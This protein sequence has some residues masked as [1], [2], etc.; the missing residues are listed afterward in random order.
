MAYRGCY[1]GVEIKP[2][3]PL[4]RL[5]LMVQDRLEAARIQEVM[6]GALAATG[7]QGLNDAY[8][9][10][11]QLSIPSEAERAEAQ[12]EAMHHLLANWDH[13]QD[14]F[15]QSIMPAILRVKEKRVRQE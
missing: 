12:G 8:Q 10:F 3:T 5:I 6:V 2:G 9:S 1:T 7:G 15:E 14:R 13:Q 11:V 4:D